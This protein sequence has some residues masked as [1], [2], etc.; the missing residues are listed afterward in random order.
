MNNIP[1]MTSAFQRMHPSKSE[2]REASPVIKERGRQ[3]AIKM[4]AEVQDWNKREPCSNAGGNLTQK[5]SILTEMSS[6]SSL[7]EDRKQKRKK[8]LEQ[9]LR[10]AKRQGRLT[11]SMEAK[12]RDDFHQ[13]QEAEE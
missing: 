10:E 2:G 12:M 9:F 5:P 8:V 7:I 6:E 11:E 3:E 1:S 4:A 13:Q